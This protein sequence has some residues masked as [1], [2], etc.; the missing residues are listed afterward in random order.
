MNQAQWLDPLFT[1]NDYSNLEAILGPR[2]EI[3]RHELDDLMNILKLMQSLK[4]VTRSHE[5][6]ELNRLIRSIEKTLVI[7][8]EPDIAPWLRPASEISK[9]KALLVTTK[10][11]LSRYIEFLESLSNRDLKLGTKRIRKENLLLRFLAQHLAKSFR[12]HELDVTITVASETSRD[13]IFVS[14]VRIMCDR[15]DIP[16]PRDLRK[17]LH[18]AM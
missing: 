9:L 10:A 12:Y 17:L 8:D 4:P 18:S 11:R 14:T 16:I 6:N 1:E 15:L 5:I 2:F 7:L 3:L 13:S